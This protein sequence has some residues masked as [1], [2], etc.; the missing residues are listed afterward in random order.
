M[1]D[2][3]ITHNC[4][5]RNSVYVSSLLSDVIVNLLPVALECFYKISHW[6]D[7]ESSTCR[8]MSQQMTAIQQIFL[9]LLL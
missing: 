9:S 4:I 3:E 5:T 8:E 1:V 6:F 2:P 7:A